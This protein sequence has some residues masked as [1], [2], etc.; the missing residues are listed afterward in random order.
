MSGVANPLTASLPVVV[1][2]SVIAAV[3]YVPASDP[4][5]LELFLGGMQKARLKKEYGWGSGLP[6]LPRAGC[7]PE[8]L[9]QADA[10]CALAQKE[11]EGGRDRRILERKA[12]RLEMCGRLGELFECLECTRAWKRGWNCSLRSC[13]LCGRKIFDRAFA[14]L[15]PLEFHVPGAL[16]SLP[17]WGWK[18]FDYTFYHDG[19]FPS[20]EQMRKMRGV[21]N[22]V[23]DRAVREKCA[24]MQRSGRGCKL[25]FNSDDG[26]PMMFEG[27]P[28]VSAPDGSARVL[29][30]WTVVRPGK[31]GKC[32]TCVC[33]GSRVKKVKRE[34]T[35]LCP[36]CGPRQW[37][38]WENQDTD[39]RRW[40]LRFGVLHIPVSEFAFDN[41]NYHFHT[42]FFG[43]YLEQARVVEI[44]R[45]ESLKAL[46]VES[47]GV[48][49]E[50]AKRGYRSVLAH[51]L[52]YTAKMPGSTPERLA[53]YEKVLMGVRR[54]AVRGFLQGVV[55]GEKKRG[56]P[57]CP[58]CKKSLQRITG[59][60]L[61]P[62]SEVE[63]IPFLLEEEADDCTADYKDDEFC[64]YEEEEMAARA[65]RAPC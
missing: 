33:C 41:T 12:R 11:E 51:A 54:Y 63:D 2:G 8:R 15:L 46:G 19:S 44:F 28:V 61:V 14:E 32:L 60:G 57:K 18:I 43:P 39:N 47:R 53:E 56:E 62:L 40:R 13:W 31:V 1:L 48:W 58:V 65:P 22:R 10:L 24:E 16:A 37:P 55:L 4:A 42:C 45:E 36:K 25:R 20:R 9:A 38:D 64:F 26:S 59:L 49:I 7:A 23:T 50:S 35:R 29:V 21:V 17:G 27:W 5:A 34:R 52:K 30:G 3:P 6:E